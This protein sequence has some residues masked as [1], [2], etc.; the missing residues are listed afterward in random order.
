MRHRQQKIHLGR[1]LGHR[2]ALLK[3]LATSLIFYET[4]DTTVA[5]AKILRSYVEPLISLARTDTLAGRRRA[6]VK[7]THKNAVKKLFEVLGP[8]YKSRPGGYTRLRRKTRRAG[9]AA[10]IATLAFVE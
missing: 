8:K 5:K 6:L 9:D 2:R 4:I 10:E 1:Q 7:L 3:N